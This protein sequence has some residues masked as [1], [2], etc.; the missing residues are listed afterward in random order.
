M[1]ATYPLGYQ[2][3][4]ELRN[5]IKHAKDRYL[6]NDIELAKAYLED[7]RDLTV[8]GV[9]YDDRSI[10]DVQDEIFSY[11]PYSGNTAEP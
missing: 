11:N 3:M 4:P 8:F 7:P 9:Y 2:S 1:L 10:K 6:K 5:L